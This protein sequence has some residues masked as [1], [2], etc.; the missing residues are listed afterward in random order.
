MHI[1]PIGEELFLT[2][3]KRLCVQSSHGDSSFKQ[4]GELIHRVAPIV[5]RHRPALADVALLMLRSAR[6]INL[7]TASSLGKSGRF[8]MILRSVI[9][10]DS[11]SRTRWCWWCSPPAAPLPGSQTLERPCPSWPATTARSKGKHGLAST[12]FIKKSA[13]SDSINSDKRLRF[14]P[15][16][17]YSSSGASHLDA[18]SFLFRTAQGKSRQLAEKPM[19]RI[20]AWEMVQRRLEGAGIGGHLGFGCHSFRAAC[21]TNFLAHGGALETCQVLMG[22]ADSRTTKLYNRRAL[23]PTLAE[24]DR[25]RYASE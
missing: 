2:L 8:L 9:F 14:S 23:Q 15:S 18:H 21:G 25:I 12:Y 17:R 24:I 16:Q 3:C 10:K 4:N 6:Y 11:I 5:N 22:H 13:S 20:H 19:N 7:N 1:I